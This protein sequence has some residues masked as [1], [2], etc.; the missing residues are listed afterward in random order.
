MIT[1]PAIAGQVEMFTDLH[2]LRIYLS[3]TYL[4]PHVF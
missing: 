1:P 2:E 4:T 3:M